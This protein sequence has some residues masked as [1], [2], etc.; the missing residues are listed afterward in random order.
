MAHTAV[1]VDFCRQHWKGYAIIV[2]GSSKETEKEAADT[3]E[4]K[5]T[6]GQFCLFVFVLQLFLGP[7]RV[8][9]LLERATLDLI[10]SNI[11][12]I[13]HINLELLA[14]LRANRANP[15]KSFCDLA[16]FL[17]LYSLYAENFQ[18][19]IEVVVVSEACPGRFLSPADPLP[20]SM[21]TSLCVSLIL[22]VPSL[23]PFL[24]FCLC[25]SHPVRA[26]LSSLSL[27]LFA[28]LCLFSPAVC[29]FP[30]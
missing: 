12:D 19:A 3:E 13:R 1:V 15:G 26:F 28:S 6:R 23:A 29:L 14:S 17:K 5:K 18:R 4:Y 30:L 11:E 7:L 27:L 21:C 20:V 9:P 24:F 8:N 25:V 22:Y 2:L 16:P 10:F